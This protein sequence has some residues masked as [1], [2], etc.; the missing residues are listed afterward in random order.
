MKVSGFTFLNN[1]VTMG[2]PF[3]QSIMSALPIC[4]EFIV[5]VGEIEDGTAEAVAAI[6]DPKIKIYRSTWNPHVWVYA[7]AQQTNIA[8]FN[9][10]GDWAF[11]IQ[12]D[13]V[14]HEDDYETLR[15]SMKKHLDDPHVEGLTFD[16]V[17]FYGNHNTQAWSPRWYR[18]EIR[19]IRNNL[20]VIFPTDGLFPILLKSSTKSRYLKAVASGAKMY[21]YGWVHVDNYRTGGQNR[22]TDYSQVDSKSLRLFCGTHP[23]IMQEIL[24][25]DITEP[26]APDPSYKLVARDKKHRVSMFFEKWFGIDL[27]KKHFIPVKPT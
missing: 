22:P 5:V 3:R 25:L 14:I 1:A 20:R 2:Y 19:I 23:L 11:S 10:T 26:F 27:S 24:R 12:G 13:E 4:D 7:F 9:C 21:H 16:Y 15:A 17:H 8:L 18:K 6:G